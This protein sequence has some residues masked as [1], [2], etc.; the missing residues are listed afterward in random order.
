LV[1]FLR[2]FRLGAYRTGRAAG[3]TYKVLFELLERRCGQ[4]DGEWS[5]GCVLVR[6]RD[7]RNLLDAGGEE[8][9]EV[10]VFRELFC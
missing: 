5:D 2:E 9:E 10:G 3:C 1:P 8:E 6:G 7:T 4:D